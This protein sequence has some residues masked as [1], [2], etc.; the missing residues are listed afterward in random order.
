LFDLGIE[1]KEAVQNLVAV[2]GVR[3]TYHTTT[4]MGEKEEP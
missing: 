2:H 4:D 3:G 1:F